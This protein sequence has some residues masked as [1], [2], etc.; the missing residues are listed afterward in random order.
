MKYVYI[1]IFLII[2]SPV[3]SQNKTQRNAATDIRKYKTELNLTVEQM[4]KLNT[5]Y[6]N[7]NSRVSLQAPEKNW[8]ENAK[9]NN[10]IRQELRKEVQQVLT[11]EQQKTFTQL[12]QKQQKTAIKKQRK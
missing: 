1:I 8:K 3:F 6:N 2:A 12:R 9:K 7:Y 4:G 11:P 5:I 10:A